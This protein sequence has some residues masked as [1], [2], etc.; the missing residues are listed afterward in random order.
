MSVALS[1]VLL[2]KYRLGFGLNTHQNCSPN[3]SLNS[4]LNKNFD[5]PSSRISAILRYPINTQD[6]D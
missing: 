1:S 2:I 3:Q 4:R 5:S 6:Q